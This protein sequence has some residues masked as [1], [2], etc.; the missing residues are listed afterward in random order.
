MALKRAQFKEK[1]QERLWTAACW[2]DYQ[3]VS[4]QKAFDAEIEQIE[5]E[6]EAEKT[7]LKERLLSELFEQKKRLLE[8]RDTGDEGNSERG[9]ERL[10]PN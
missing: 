4:V 3:L 5:R 1:L 10:A 7:N 8:G 9:M 6:F 2:R